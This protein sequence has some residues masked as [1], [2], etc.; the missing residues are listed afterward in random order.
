MPSHLVTGKVFEEKCCDQ[1]QGLR[2]PRMAFRTSDPWRLRHYI[3]SK[4][5]AP[6]NR[7][8]GVRFHKKGAIKHTAAKT[9]RPVL[10]P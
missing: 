4:S 3:P 6:V 9:S 1:L 10:C 8:H 7:L 5:Q 2:D